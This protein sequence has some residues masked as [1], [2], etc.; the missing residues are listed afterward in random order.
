MVL[1]LACCCLFFAGAAQAAAGPPANITM[2]PMS[3]GVLTADG[4]SQASAVVTLTDV[5]G[6]PVTGDA[7]GLQVTSSDPAVGFGPVIDDGNGSYTVSVASS[8]T[9]HQVAITVT[10]SATGI[11]ASQPLIQ[12]HGPAQQIGVQLAPA[13]L[14]ANGVSTTTATVSVADAHGNPIAGDAVVL[15]AANPA[16]HLGPVADHGNGTYTAKV[17]G[18]I[19]PGTTTITATDVSSAQTVSGA[20]VLTQTPAPSLVNIATMQWTFFY[21]RSYTVVRSLVLNGAPSGASISV[22]CSGAGCPFTSLRLKTDKQPKCSS[23]A[24]RPCRSGSSLVLTPGLARRQ[25]HRGAKL[26]VLIARRGWIGKYYS[27]RMRSS[28]GPVIKISC[29]APGST[30]PGAGC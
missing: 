2:S 10:E 12:V 20:A 4:T 29:L 23:R 19:T 27:F 21:T 22:V 16:A 24:H 9:A 26:S 30:R 15:S 6:N 11:S 18:S 25:L 28:T 7:T 1:G 8:T 5:S 13:V 17:Y 14:V 3:P